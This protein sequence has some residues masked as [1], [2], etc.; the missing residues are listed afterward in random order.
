MFGMMF[1]DVGH[2]LLVAALALVLRRAHSPRLAA[3]RRMWV[4]PFAAG[5]SAAL[6]G[7]LYGECFG[8]TGLV[9]RLWLDPVDEP[10]PLLAV[11]VAVGAALLAQSYA[12]GTVN[13]W[14]EEGVAAAI[15]APTGVAGTTVFVGAAVAAAGWYL[16]I[17]GVLIAGAALAVAGIALMAVGYA[18]AAEG[19]GAERTV[20][21]VVET[22]DGVVRIGAATIS[23]TRLAAFGLVHAALG[24]VV[25]D[26]A[27]GAWPPLAVAVF[28]IGNAVTFSLELLV[29]SI[30]ALR[31]EYYELFSH[32]FAGQGRAFAPWHIPLAKEES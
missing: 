31:L 28:L 25:W 10:T 12:F 29:A 15:V 23:F 24:A 16:D 1:G 7:L 27:S 5:L 2:G 8:P 26:A 30:Q 22:T 13:R 6:F 11:A 20:Q 3:A 4:L 17:A 14:R 18:L 21:V 32:I 9:P 19:R